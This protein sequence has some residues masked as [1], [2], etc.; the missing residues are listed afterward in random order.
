[1]TTIEPDQIC[2]TNMD[3]CIGQD[4][5]NYAYADCAFYF[6]PHPTKIVVTVRTAVDYS[7][8]LECVEA[9]LIETACH[10]LQSVAALPAESIADLHAKG[11]SAPDQDRDFPPPDLSQIL[12]DRR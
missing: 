9:K 10:I 11:R 8:S 2:I 4:G 6:R 7:E 1:M 12:Q 5:Q 3:S